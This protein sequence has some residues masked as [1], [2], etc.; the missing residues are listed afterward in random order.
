MGMNVDLI[1][2]DVDGTLLTDDHIL[3][4]QYVIPC[5]KR[6]RAEPKLFFVPDAGQCALPVLDELGLSGTL[7]TH[8]GAAT[9]EA[10]KREVIHQYRI[11]SNEV[12]TISGVLYAQWVS[13]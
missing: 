9:I 1:A 11:D 8:N 6:L 13:F 12:D 2:L 4:P 7:I 3:T 10:E 5:V